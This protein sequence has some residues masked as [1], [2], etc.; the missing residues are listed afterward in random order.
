MTD[1]VE[2]EEGGLITQPNLPVVDVEGAKAY[3]DAYKELTEAILDKETDYQLDKKSGKKFK[4]KSAWRKYATAFNF[5]TEILKEEIIRDEDQ[6]VVTAVYTVLA[7]APN[8]RSEPGVGACSIW[9]KSHEND[10]LNDKGKVICKGPCNGRK[11]FSNPENT[12][13]TTAHTRAKSRAIADLIGTGEVSAEEIQFDNNTGNTP[14][15]RG[16]NSGR[17]R[18]T[19][20]T[21]DTTRRTRTPPKPKEPEWDAVAPKAEKV[22]PK[23]PDNVQEGEVS[24]ELNTDHIFA[25]CPKGLQVAEAVRNDKKP[26]TKKNINNKAVAMMP[27]YLDAEDIKEIN[28]CIAEAEEA[29]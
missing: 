27:E 14:S 11:H 15:P 3:W 6:R 8:G 20:R 23:E 13:I 16:G 4:K 9:D 24:P 21:R 19:T 5:T 17:Q 7:I 1:I 25:S 2:Y 26:L 12:I 29:T 10:K 28:K 18:Q 22:K